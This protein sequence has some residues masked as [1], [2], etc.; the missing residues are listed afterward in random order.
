MRVLHVGHIS[1]TS[2]TLPPP[3]AA[4]QRR[5]RPLDVLARLADREANLHPQPWR[6][7]HRRR[8]T[9]RGSQIETTHQR[10]RL[11]L[12]LVRVEDAHWRAD[13]AAL[14]GERAHLCTQQ[15]KAV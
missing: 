9:Y 13:D 10:A 2:Y 6:E 12:A 1:C 8:F 3:P 5:A 4:R 15:L 7:E 14:R 11:R